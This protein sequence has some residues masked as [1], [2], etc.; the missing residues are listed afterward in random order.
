MKVGIIGGGG[1]V[2]SCAAFALQCG[3]TADEIVVVDAN[4]DAAVGEALDLMHGASVAADQ[5]ITAGTYD[6]LKDADIVVITAG[7]RRKPDE[8]R[9]ELINRNVKLFVEIL[10]SL[11]KAGLPDRSI[12][13]VVS[14]PVDILTR[15]AV[16][17]TGRCPDR[18]IGL[19]TLLDTMRFCSLIAEEVKV[20]PTQVRAMILGEHGDTMVPVWSS[21]S[22]A[23][24]PLTQWPALTPVKQN[25]LFERTK[26]SGADVIR[27]KGGAGWAV[28]LAVRE[29]IAAIAFNRR[30]VL[31]VSSR[32]NGAFGIRGTCLSVPTVIDR[33]GVVARIDLE[34]W[35]KERT[36]LA[37]SARALDETYAKVSV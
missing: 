13:L 25:Q 27:L 17:H 16:E 9:L 34:L 15:L 20:A 12:I 5:R 24:L 35:P 33:R 8:S 19:G 7:L 29:V 4:A 21:A 1:R 36:A 22:I 30:R 31:P 37:T 26:T 18:T 3:A 10:D 11:K 23:G 28:G 14:N 6:D 32:Q 2:G